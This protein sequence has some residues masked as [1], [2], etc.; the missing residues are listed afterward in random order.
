MG[1]NIFQ[2]LQYNDFVGLQWLFYS[3]FNL[4]YIFEICESLDVHV[5]YDVE[6]QYQRTFNL[7]NPYK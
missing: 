4:Y 2:L 6:V 1:F 3:M 5:Q 7:T